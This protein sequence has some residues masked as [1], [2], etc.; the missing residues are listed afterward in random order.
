M[1]VVFWVAAFLTFY[2]YI[3]YFCWLW[4]RARWKA[5]SS[6]RQAVLPTVSVIVAVRNEGARLRAK[7]SNLLACDY[8]RELLQL[9]FVSDGSAD[10]TDSILRESQAQVEP[11]FLAQSQGKAAALNAGIAAARGE[12]LLF[13]DARQQFEPQAIRYLVARFVEPQ[14]GCVSGE[15]MLRPS[16]GDGTA[17][18]GFYWTLEKKIRQLESIGGSV[19]GAT[20]AI[21]AA[22]RT[23]VRDLPVGTILDDVLIPMR[24]LKDRYRVV[25][26]PR[27]LAWDSLS[28]LRG[29]EFRRKV[30]TLFG[31][32]QLIGLAPWLLTAGNPALFNFVSHKVLRLLGPLFLLALLLAAA[33]VDGPF[34]RLA[35][36]MQLLFYGLALLSLAHPRISPVR[37]LADAASAF[38]SL[39]AAAVLAFVYFVSGKKGVWVR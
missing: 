3:G 29:H 17:G 13:T 5:E 39:N 16:A 12:I 7:I 8:P 38:V 30:R 2:T 11:L 23:V 28:E 31:N 27:A 20:G 15:L 21:Y 9:I 14:V 25:F 24:I 34:Y 36:L 35:L 10:E 1:K 6:A 22:R 19:I 32:Y 37:K 33:V 26:E 4:L 18:F